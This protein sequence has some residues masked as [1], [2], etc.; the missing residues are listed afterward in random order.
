M[1]RSPVDAMPL[2]SP[3]PR[4]P[5]LVRPAVSSPAPPGLASHHG[6]A[7]VVE[8]EGRGS[9]QRDSVRNN[10]HATEANTPHPADIRKKDN[11]KGGMESRLFLSHEVLPRSYS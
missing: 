4:V 2:P 6:D 8:Q 5:T 3:V 7:G 9:R 11:K 1:N 10:R